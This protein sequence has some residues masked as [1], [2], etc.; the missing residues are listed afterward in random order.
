[1]KDAPGIFEHNNV[2]LR[3]KLKETMSQSDSLIKLG[4]GGRAH[5]GGRSGV[6]G[7]AKGPARERA[8]GSPTGRIPPSLW[9]LH[10]CGASNVRRK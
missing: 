7:A 2:E 3:K 10:T 5:L 6:V 4:L 9:M 1:M 8:K